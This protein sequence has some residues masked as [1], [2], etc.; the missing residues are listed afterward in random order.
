MDVRTAVP[1]TAVSDVTRTSRERP[2]TKLKFGQ[3]MTF[4]RHLRRPQ[5][6][7]GTSAT[8][9]DV[10]RP[11]S[12]RQALVSMTSDNDVVFTSFCEQIF[13]FSGRQNLT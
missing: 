1:R 8:Y 7:Q 5:N 3:N 2:L 4:T 11:F 13:L 12:G 9:S 6:I 10:N